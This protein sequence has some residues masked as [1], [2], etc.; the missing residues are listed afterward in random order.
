MRTIEIT[1]GTMSESVSTSLRRFPVLPGV[2]SAGPLPG[3]VSV[4]LTP[5][6]PR[7]ALPRPSTAMPEAPGFP[8][9]APQLIIPIITTPPTIPIIRPSSGKHPDAGRRGCTAQGWR[10][11]VCSPFS[12]WCHSAPPPGITGQRPLRIIP[13]P[14]EAAI[15]IGAQVASIRTLTQPR[16]T[17]SPGTTGAPCHTLPTHIGATMN[18][19]NVRVKVVFISMETGAITVSWPAAR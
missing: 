5:S 7:R 13:L 8:S 15:A 16:S 4:P 14:S 18:A 10:C 6:L 2:Y 3:A 12:S 9:L 1:L 17:G 19:E 11:G